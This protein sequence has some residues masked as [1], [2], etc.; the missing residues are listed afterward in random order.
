MKHQWGEFLGAVFGNRIPPAHVGFVDAEMQAFITRGCAVKWTD[1]Q[2][3]RIDSLC[4]CGVVY[5]RAQYTA[6]VLGLLYGLCCVCEVV[7]RLACLAL[8]RSYW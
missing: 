1:V 4:C 6:V 7:F 2:G 5:Y 3:C 8:Q